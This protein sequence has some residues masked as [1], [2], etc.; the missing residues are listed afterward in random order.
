MADCHACRSA[1]TETAL[2]AVLLLSVAIIP[3][4]GQQ[5]QLFVSN[6]VTDTVQR[7]DGSTGAFIDTFASGGGLNQPR[8]LAFSPHDNNLYVVSELTSEIKRYDGITG[9]FI[10]T[11]A[12]MNLRAS[13][14][15]SFQRK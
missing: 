12:S 10:D 8:D 7:Y 6:S 4:S 2:V 1:L 11:F 13:N 3:A 15:M 14:R 9:A 5:L